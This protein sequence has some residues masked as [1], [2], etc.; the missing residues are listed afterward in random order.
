MQPVPTK[1]LLLIAQN[2][3]CF[4]CGNMIDWNT[5]TKDHMIPQSKGGGGGSNIVLACVRCNSQ[6]ADRWPTFEEFSR[7]KSIHGHLPHI[8]VKEYASLIESLRQRAPVKPDRPPTSSLRWLLL[9]DGQTKGPNKQWQF[10]LQQGKCFYC[11]EPM[12]FRNARR[13]LL[14]PRC[15][16]GGEGLNVVLA[17]W[18]CTT[19]KRGTFIT[20]A[21]FAKWAAMHGRDEKSG[22]P[23]K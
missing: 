3:E 20:T 1:A 11:D 9:S 17:C 4:F 5:A 16:G 18:G 2:M 6:K 8:D 14:V 22:E 13:S 12:V 10:D 7:A 21:Q 15:N 19:F 23:T